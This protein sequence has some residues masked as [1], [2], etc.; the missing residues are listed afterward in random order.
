MGQSSSF[1][2]DFFLEVCFSNGQLRNVDVFRV[3]RIGWSK[4]VASVLR[5]LSTTLVM[6]SVT[7][8][9]KATEMGKKATLSCLAVFGYPIERS[10]FQSKLLLVDK[11]KNMLIDEMGTLRQTLLTWVNAATAYFRRCWMSE[12]YFRSTLRNGLQNR[13]RRRRSERERER[14]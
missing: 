9:L 12:A 1:N 6:G 11:L 2:A 5:N 13:R 7:Y 3:L 10:Y 14:D 4:A 8:W